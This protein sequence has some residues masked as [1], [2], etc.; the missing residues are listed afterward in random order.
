MRKIFVSGCYDI[1]HAGHIQFFREARALGDFLTVCFAS[2]DVLWLHKNR[3]S[4]LPDEHKRALLAGLRVVDEVVVGCGTEE[5]IDFREHFLR[6]RPQVLAV[7]EDDKYAPLKKALCAEVGAEY[8]VLPKTPPEFPPIST[9]EIVRYIRA[10]QEAPMRVDFGGG[11]LDV[12]KFARPG[13]YIVNCSITPTVSL[14]DWP[15]ERNAGLGGSG[16][17]ALLNGKNGVTAEL[18]LGVGWQDPAIIAETGLCIWKS[19]ARP[20]LELKHHGGFLRGR[21][22]LYWTGK[23]HDT[24]GVVQHKRDLDAIEAAGKTA[25]DAVWASS[26]EGLA[27]A[28]G[29]SYAVQLGEGMD[30]LPAKGAGV[31]AM[32][33]S[34]GGFGGYALYLCATQEVRDA[35]CQEEGFRPI[36]PYVKS[37]M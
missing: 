31:L 18:D 22:A 4:S 30:P 32:K 23:P 37:G 10:P 17:W 8:V 36:E 1:I 34:G 35:L 19:G 28:V 3:R 14:R 24:P 25:R 20:E 9:S 12:P 33:Y 11:W 29:Q 16:A 21:M 5:G 6:I 2:A 15:Y 26:L 27:Q 13:A 7:T